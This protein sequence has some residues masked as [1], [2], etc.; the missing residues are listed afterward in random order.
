[1]LSTMSY[2]VTVAQLR[3]GLQSHVTAAL[4]DDLTMTFCGRPAQLGQ[5]VTIMN[6]YFTCEPA[7]PL[8]ELRTF[9][10]RRHEYWEGQLEGCIGLGVHCGAPGAG[11]L[12][13]D[14]DAGYLRGVLTVSMPAAVDIRAGKP[15]NI[16]CTTEGILYELS[17]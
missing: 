8:L 14:H 9:L 4:W 1:M 6:F 13:C 17:G 7:Q 12:T 11:Q 3:D 16:R 5:A 15:Y 2:H 10:A